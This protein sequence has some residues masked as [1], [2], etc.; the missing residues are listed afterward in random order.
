MD[1][2][3]KTE[4]MNRLNHD[5]LYARI[6]LRGVPTLTSI[7]SLLENKQKTLI[8]KLEADIN[9]PTSKGDKFENKSI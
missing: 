7:K 6:Y 5:I 2:F 3:T 8:T 9:H 4:H 1:T